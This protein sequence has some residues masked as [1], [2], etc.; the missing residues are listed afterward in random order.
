MMSLI[1][2]QTHI[3]NVGHTTTIVVVVVT[4]VVDINGVVVD[5][6]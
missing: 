6:C 5:C 4:V 3:L 1:F 2:P